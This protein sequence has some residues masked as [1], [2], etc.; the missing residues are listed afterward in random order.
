MEYPFGLA[1]LVAISVGYQTPYLLEVVIENYELRN[2]FPI[3]N[4]SRCYD[5]LAKLRS[6]KFLSNGVFLG[7]R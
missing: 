6:S 3:V 1:G 4:F 5:T 7:T 2:T